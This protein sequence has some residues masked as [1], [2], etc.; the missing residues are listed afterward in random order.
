MHITAELKAYWHTCILLQF[1]RSRQKYSSHLLKVFSILASVTESKVCHQTMRLRRVFRENSGQR[2][3]IEVY[4]KLSCMSP[5]VSLQSVFRF[6]H[7]R[8]R[9]CCKHLLCRV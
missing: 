4:L 9:W 2:K 6:W 3:L 5:A 7:C 8:R 1:I